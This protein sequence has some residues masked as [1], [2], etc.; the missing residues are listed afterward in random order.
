M[1]RVKG[2][3]E[4]GIGGKGEDRERGGEGNA[5]GEWESKTYD[6]RKKKM[7]MRDE[8]NGRKNKKEERKE[9][10]KRNIGWVGG[11][12]RKGRGAEGREGRVGLTPPQFPPP[13]GSPFPLLPHPRAAYKTLHFGDIKKISP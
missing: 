5:G 9:E 8:T 4:R 6:R 2:R 1:R 7:N 10:K 3:G 13:T 12:E 11:K